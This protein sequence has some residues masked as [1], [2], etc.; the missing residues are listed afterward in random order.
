MN[1][2]R[3]QYG[4]NIRR[5]STQFLAWLKS[6][7]VVQLRGDLARTKKLLNGVT[8][9]RRINEGLAWIV[10]EGFKVESSLPKV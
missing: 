2:F 8:N 7:L 3:P 9:G 5:P 10:G 4:E 6:E 1:K